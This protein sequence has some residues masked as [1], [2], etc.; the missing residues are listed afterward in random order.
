MAD[1]QDF[2]QPA[3]SGDDGGKPFYKSPVKLLGAL[4]LGKKLL[5]GLVSK[6]RTHRQRE[7]IKGLRAQQR[8]RKRQ[9]RSAEARA[10][11][12]EE[13]RKDRKERLR[14]RKR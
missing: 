14:G 11:L 5:G 4:W 10:A 8:E 1:S 2:N 6:S 12:R 9:E 13:R 3:G 7:A